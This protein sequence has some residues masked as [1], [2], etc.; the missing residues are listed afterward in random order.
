MGRFADPYSASV[1]TKES[2]A[3]RN[4]RLVVQMLMAANEA[5][6]AAIAV[7]L[8]V[9]RSGVYERL[10][11]KRRIT[12]DDVRKLATYFGVDPGVFFVE[13]RRLVNLP[14]G[15]STQQ[16]RAGEKAAPRVPQ[17]KVA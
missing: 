15:R 11:G 5:D 17:A 8:G 16:V 13:P 4:V 3:D 10:S 1:A 2:D 12:I 9:A 14:T 7:V 6:A